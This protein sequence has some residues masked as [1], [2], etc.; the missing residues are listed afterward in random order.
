MRHLADD[1]IDVLAADADAATPAEVEHL[2]TCAECHTK[3]TELRALLDDLH[4][5][6]Q[7]TPAP[8]TLARYHALADAL[9]PAPSKLSALWQS[10]TAALAWDS[11]RQT[12][13]AV[14]SGALSDYRLLYTT[15]L[16][17][18]E[19][20]VSPVNA[21]RRIEGE[22]IPQEQAASPLA[23]IELEPVDA[24]NGHT[25]TTRA[26]GRFRLDAVAPGTYRMTVVPA[27]GQLHVIEQLEI[28]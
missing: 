25:V 23:M 10:V 6:A 2:T 11:R 12:A 20:M 9:E 7:A 4:L 24:E 14:R 26:D 16:V 22:F 15:P 27:H 8:A 3:L 19:L 17:D 13:G 18:I 5:Y 28:S 21:G 1:R